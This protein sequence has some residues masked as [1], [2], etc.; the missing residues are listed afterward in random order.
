MAS[1]SVLLTS[2]LYLH[3][4][5]VWWNRGEN[6]KD[7]FIVLRNLCF[8]LYYSLA[9]SAVAWGEEGEWGCI[10]G[11]LLLRAYVSDQSMWGAHI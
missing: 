7:Q 10:L 1:E 4:G 6:F 8:I 5:I 2:Y 11:G 9:E 3:T